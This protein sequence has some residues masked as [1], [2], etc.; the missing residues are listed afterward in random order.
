[1]TRTTKNLKKL[2]VVLEGLEGDL[3]EKGENK[4]VYNGLEFSRSD[5]HNLQHSINQVIK[6]YEDNNRNSKE[7][8][9]THKEYNRINRMINYYKNKD[10][11]T[12][13]DFVRLERLQKKMEV[14]LDKLDEERKMNTKLKLLQKQTQ[15]EKRK[16]EQRERNIEDDL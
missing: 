8:L 9:K 5:W 4:M 2:S 12:E 16:Y 6:V 14:Q 15:K 1:M 11:K 13:R 3:F 7:F 10:N